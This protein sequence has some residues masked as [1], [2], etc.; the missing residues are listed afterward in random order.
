M[1]HY[2]WLFKLGPSIFGM[3]ILS[4]PKILDPIIFVKRDFYV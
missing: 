3:E 1:I 4:I 2:Q